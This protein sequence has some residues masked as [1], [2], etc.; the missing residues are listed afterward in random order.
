MA[1]ALSSLGA[2]LGIMAHSMAATPWPCPGVARFASGFPGVK[3]LGALYLR[4]LGIKAIAARRF[5]S[6]VPAD[7]RPLGRIFLTGLLS[8]LLNPKPGLFVVTFIPQ[9]VS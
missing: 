2:G 6:F 1:A 9:F 3:A 8:N 4:W 7:R 5:I